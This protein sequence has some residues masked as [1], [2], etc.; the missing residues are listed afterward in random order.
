MLEKGYQPSLP[1]FAKMKN[2]ELFLNEIV[3]TNEMAQG[4]AD[5]IKVTKKFPDKIVKGLIIE[6]CNMRDD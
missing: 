2:H 4:L 6:N 5:Y 3:I 1:T